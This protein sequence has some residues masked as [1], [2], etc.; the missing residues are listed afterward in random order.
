MMEIDRL[1]WALPR[2]PTHAVMLD[3]HSCL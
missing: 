3:S 1:F 2:A